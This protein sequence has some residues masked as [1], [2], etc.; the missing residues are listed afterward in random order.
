[1]ADRP[2]KDIEEALSRL[3]PEIDPE[4]PESLAQYVQLQGDAVVAHL[5]TVAILRSIVQLFEDECTSD[6]MAQLVAITL[7]A[8]DRILRAGVTL[9]M[10][11]RGD[12]PDAVRD[13]QRRYKRRRDQILAAAQAV[14]VSMGRIVFRLPK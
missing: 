7:D 2:W 11:D 13:A 5:T 10:I 6:A 8:S 12:L 3:L 14:N 9:Y 4:N 1:M